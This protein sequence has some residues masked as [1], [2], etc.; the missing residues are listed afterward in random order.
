MNALPPPGKRPPGALRSLFGVHAFCGNDC[1][2][3]SAMPNHGATDSSKKC[4]TSW[5]GLCTVGSAF[6]SRGNDSRKVTSAPEPGREE[7][8]RVAG[9]SW[10]T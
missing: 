3:H 8:K 1:G 4:V 9:S 7:R 10:P 5:P 6:G 2:S